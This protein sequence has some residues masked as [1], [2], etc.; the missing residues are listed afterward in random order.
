ME[1]FMKITKG[2]CGAAVSF[3]L[4]LHAMIQLLTYA[5]LLDIATGLLRA[6]MNKDISSEETRKGMGRK[7]M[8]L[9][10]VAGAEIAGRHLSIEVSL[11]WGGEWGIG[12]A[13]AGYYLVHEAISIV[14]NLGQAGVPFPAFLAGRL[15]RL[16]Q[17]FDEEEEQ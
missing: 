2:I 16:R 3:F 10:T 6:W 12:A 4:G 5:I 7:A 11:P 13:L 9:L 15:K 8:I 14:E 1:Q 17:A